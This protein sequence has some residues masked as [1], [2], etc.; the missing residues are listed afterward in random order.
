M[1]FFQIFA[2]HLFSGERFCYTV[3]HEMNFSLEMSLLP[4][5]RLYL[6]R[7]AKLRMVKS[8]PN[9]LL[10][11]AVLMLA[12]LVIEM[13]IPGVLGLSNLPIDVP[14]KITSY[15]AYMAAS[16][17]AAEQMMVFLEHYRPSTIGL[18]LAGLLYLMHEM[19]HVGFQIYTLNLAR[20]RK[21]EFGN[22]LDAFPIFGRVLVLLLLQLV[23]V[24][25]LT[26]LLI[27][28]GVIMSYRYRQ[29]LYLLV[30]HPDYSPVRCLQE[31]GRLMRGHKL[32][33]FVTDL[34]FLGWLLAQM[35]VPFF[36]SVIGIYVMPYM[37]ITFANFY[38]V[39]S[40]PLQTPD[41]KPFQEGQFTESGGDRKDS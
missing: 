26:L 29:A 1:N 35:F 3:G 40:G 21:V 18:I 15:D 23:I 2:T 8:K 30:E 20:D 14:E 7:D 36:G 28:P 6:K 33:L 4:I 12:Y 17:K 32:E 27:F 5:N 25:A 19:L 22:L 41:G 13:L 37:E 11:S 39:L 31:S 9:A 24:S 16:E 38:C 10:V 34:S